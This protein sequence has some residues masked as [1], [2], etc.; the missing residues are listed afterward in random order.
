MAATTLT[1]V[2]PGYIDRKGVGKD[3]LDKEMD[4]LIM[5]SNKTVLQGARFFRTVTSKS[6]TYKEGGYGNDLPLPPASED[7]ANMPFATPTPDFSKEIT[8]VNRRLAIQVERSMAEDELFPVARKMMSGLIRVG[9]LS[10]E[11]M[12]ADIMNNLTTDTATYWGAD[13]VPVASASHPFA[14]RSTGTWSNL[15]SSTALTSTT[16]FTARKN[17]RNRTD[18]RGYKCPIMPVLLVGPADLA[19]K[20]SELASSDLVPESAMN[21]AH[22]A[23]GGKGTQWMVYDYLTDTNAWFLWGDLPADDNGFLFFQKVA[24]SI[25]PLEGQDKA[26]DIIWGQRLRMRVGAG[27]RIQ[28]NIQYN[29]GA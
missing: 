19:K 2:Q 12:L 29:A 28:R 22:T 6:G 14:R 3:A 26:T 20:M 25:A 11:Y 21:T 15:E 16:Y 9:K 13:G 7:A 27:V 18:T 1:F 10:I 8:V 23:E 17:M 5:V 24:P 4:K